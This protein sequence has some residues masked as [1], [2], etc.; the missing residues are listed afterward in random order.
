MSAATKHWRR[1]TRNL[2]VVGDYPA[3]A[4][5]EARQRVTDVLTMVITAFQQIANEQG[6]GLC[7]V[8]G[9]NSPADTD[10]ALLAN[11]LGLDL[12][13][14]A[15]HV[16][17]PVASGRVG[18]QRVAVVADSVQAPPACGAAQAAA[19]EA[20]LAF[21]DAVVAVW[22][23]SLPPACEARLTNLMAEALRRHLPIVWVDSRAEQAGVVR[24]LDTRLLDELT[25]AT[26]GASEQKLGHVADQFVQMEGD[27]HI[28]LAELL[29]GY[30]DMTTIGELVAR[31]Q[32]RGGD[33][34]SARVFAGWLHRLFF[35]PFS[36]WK[37]RRPGV[38]QA[39]RGPPQFVDASGLPG[40]TWE[41][42][43][44]LD[45]AA[46]CAAHRHR[47]AVVGI[48]L[49]A[50]LAVL[51]AVLGV[52]GPRWHIGFAV[53]E[54]FFLSVAWWLFSNNS[55]KAWGHDAWLQFRQAAEAFRMNALLHPMLAS[56]PELYRKVWAYDPREQRKVRI[57]KP[58]HW[59][60]IQLFRDAGV[61][62]GRAAHCIEA[63]YFELLG[64]LAAMVENQG[65][66]HRSACKRYETTEHRFEIVLQLFLFVA[67]I[68]ALAEAFD[69][70]PSHIFPSIGPLASFLQTAG[71][72][73]WLLLLTAFVPALAAAFHG[74]RGKIEFRRL[75]RNSKRLSARLD[76]LKGTIG[77]LRYNKDPMA[78]RTV[79][80][81]TA[82]T[83][84]AE[85]ASW[86]ELAADQYLEAV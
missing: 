49:C 31:L 81:D 82:M 40:E 19:D 44:R 53:V 9:L 75:A 14:V 33:P 61:P 69:W 72:N 24:I 23:R 20:M 25:L 32:G 8:T 59:L 41:W 36:A 56:L 2:L 13:V 16:P 27:F 37:P 18:A 65:E 1:A 78:L 46:S 3:T 50:G 28:G 60:V 45:R 30:W 74:I 4:G 5:Q 35:W 76:V 67:L 79:A 51:F 7:I 29:S 66:F 77:L 17:E 80:I 63:C 12:H 83:M 39:D 86:A 21:A 85:H 47:D 57:D 62:G 11:R 71:E 84:F 73:R 64:A 48:N 34:G 6:A 15:P 52:V 68:A 26:L 42:F 58:Y 43:D 22:D 38:I 54:V 10:T 70:H 55:L